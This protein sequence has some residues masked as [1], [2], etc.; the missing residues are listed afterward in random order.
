VTRR[1]AAA[2]AA[3]ALGSSAAAPA[4]ATPLQTPPEIA[5]VTKLWR[6]DE[7]ALGFPAA[8]RLAHG[9]QLPEEGDDFF[10]WDSNLARSPNRSWRRWGTQHLVDALI[11][12]FAEYS[13]AEPLSTRIGVQDI[14]RRH[15]GV[16]GERF[17]GL[18]HSSHQNGLDA[19]I[20]YP[21]KDGLELGIDSPAEVDLERA[22]LLVD[23]FVK[24]GARYVFV[25]PRLS[26][27]GPRGVV[28]KLR[29]HDDHMHV[30]ILCPMAPLSAP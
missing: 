18:G 21:R 27:R 12:V 5:P 17:G 7:Q 23:L 19:D 28:Q 22:Q 16:F 9:V 26:L 13:Q 4:A 29:Y 10:T 1:G 30:R 2:L 14:S 11:E 15:G 8:G 24:A 3:L 6:C 20:A 25:G